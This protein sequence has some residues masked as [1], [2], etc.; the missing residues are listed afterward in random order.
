MGFLY[1]V[2]YMFNNSLNQSFIDFWTVCIKFSRNLT[3]GLKIAKL[4]TT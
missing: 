1:G 2:L 3:K 4:I